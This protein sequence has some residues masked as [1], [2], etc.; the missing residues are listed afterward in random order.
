MGIVRRAAIRLASMIGR[1]RAVMRGLLGLT[2]AISVASSAMPDQSPSPEL[3]SVL[4]DQSFNEI[5]RV[6]GLIASYARSAGE[7]A[8]RG[9]ETTMGLHIRQLRLCCLSMI[10][11]YKDFLEGT[12]G[13]QAPR[14]PAKDAR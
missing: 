12:H 10:K 11:T 2:L 14:R 3:L 4:R 1:L 9:D 5:E 6:A 7:A 13:Q 8:F